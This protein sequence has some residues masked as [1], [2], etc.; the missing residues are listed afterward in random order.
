M[1]CLRGSTFGIKK[2]LVCLSANSF[3]RRVMASY[4][5]HWPSK[6][7]L[8]P[9]GFSLPLQ[10]KSTTSSHGVK[11]RPRLHSYVVLYVCLSFP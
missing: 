8:Y 11:D 2:V 9:G 6:G 4:V 1:R 7:V 3:R 5:E 10:D